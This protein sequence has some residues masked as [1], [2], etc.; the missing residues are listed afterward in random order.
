MTAAGTTYTLGQPGKADV[1]ASLGQTFALPAGHD[2]ALRV[3][4]AAVNGSQRNQL[5]TVTY[6]D[7]TRTRVRQSVT[8][9]TSSR[10]FP[11][12]S[13]ASTMAYRDTS[14]GA[15]FVAPTRV[16]SLTL[17]LNR[18][19]T[20]RSVTLPNNPNV[21][22]LGISVVPATTRIRAA[23]ARAIRQAAPPRTR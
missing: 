3:L 5:F 12:E 13:V 8:D 7:G 10:L 6:T 9:W 14:G 16:F 17:T 15:P 21:E 4:A 11:G 19:K 18:N 23:A 22:V 2:V 1:V 20:V